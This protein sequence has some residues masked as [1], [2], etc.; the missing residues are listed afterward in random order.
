MKMRAI[1]Y[2]YY[3]WLE[4]RVKVNAAYDEKVRILKGG[5]K[6]IRTREEFLKVF[7]NPYFAPGAI[8]AMYTSGMIDDKLKPLFGL[9]T[10]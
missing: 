3:R 4:Y 10:A 1:R 9:R 6:Y 7:A 2:N 8:H 5:P